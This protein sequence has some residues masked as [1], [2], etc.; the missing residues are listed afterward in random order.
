MK[1][2]QFNLFFED[3]GTSRFVIFNAKS[4]ALAVISEKEMELYKKLFSSNFE[5]TNQ[6]EKDFLQE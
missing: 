6:E 1:Q 3:K 2:S 4:T 5:Y